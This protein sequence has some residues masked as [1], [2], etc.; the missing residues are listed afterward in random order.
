MMCLKWT[1]Y[2]YE[3]CPP[4]DCGKILKD[5][6]ANKWVKSASLCMLTVASCASHT[7][8]IRSSLCKQGVPLKL[9]QVSSPQGTLVCAMFVKSS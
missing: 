3:P 1:W 8:H 9:I 5:C 6:S 4:D 7:T 2:T